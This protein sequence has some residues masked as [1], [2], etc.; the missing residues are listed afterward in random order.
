[1]ARFGTPERLG[2]LAAQAGNDLLLYAGGYASAS[3]SADA[4]VREASAGRVSIPATRGS[5]RRV[6]AL[7]ASL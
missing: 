2:I 1:M 6:L 4:L 7:R 5:V 3:R